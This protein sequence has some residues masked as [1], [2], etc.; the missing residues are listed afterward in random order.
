MD[1]L[2][3]ETL[4]QVQQFSAILPQYI[5]EDVLSCHISMTPTKLRLKQRMDVGDYTFR[6]YK[7][8][9]FCSDHAEAAGYAM[10][11]APGGSSF[12]LRLP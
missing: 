1:G 7:V 3:Y 8:L 10:E 11:T 9:S 5:G 2:P 4:S 6:W 12:V